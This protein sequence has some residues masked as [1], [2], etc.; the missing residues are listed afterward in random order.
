MDIES[1][2][3]TK[4][5]DLEQTNS[6]DALNV[7]QSSLPP[8]EEYVKEIAPLWSS[9][10]LTNMGPKHEELISQLKEYLRVD[11]LTL[12]SNGHSALE[13]IIRAY[14]LRGEIITTPFSFASTTHAIVR[15][16]LKPVFSDIKL[17]S[18]NMDPEKIEALITEETS[19]L[20]PVHVYG[21]PC[22]IEKIQAIADKYGLIVIYDAAHTFGVEYKRASL[23]SYGDASIISFHATKVFN[24]VEGGAACYKDSIIGEE[25][26]LQKNF[27]ITGPESVVAVGGN[28]K[29]DELSASMGICNLRYVDEEIDMRKKLAAIYINKLTA[30]P[31]MT[32]CL[33]KEDADIY[34]SNFSYLPIIINSLEYGRTRDQLCDYLASYQIYAR[35]YFYPLINNYECYRDNYG[36]DTDVPIAELIASQILTLPLHSGMSENDV[37]TICEYVLSFGKAAK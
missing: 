26:D 10:R 2:S 30:I 37:V 14:N 18:C 19:A 1:M 31:G 7:T 34:Q 8:F 25:L 24:T 6:T 4:E 32:I 3:S 33:Q 12:F 35:K 22:E 16:G 29:M 13:A 17:P 5:N 15:T 11:G 21:N 36:R 9:H 27:G 23:A 28:A 20:L